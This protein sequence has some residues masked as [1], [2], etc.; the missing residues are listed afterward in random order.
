MLHVVTELLP[1]Q[2]IVRTP[3][4][5]HRHYIYDI[6]YNILYKDTLTTCPTRLLSGPTMFHTSTL[7]SLYWLGAPPHTVSGLF[8]DLIPLFPHSSHYGTVLNNM[9]RNPPMTCIVDVMLFR[10]CVLPVRWLLAVVAYYDLFTISPNMKCS[11]FM[12][13]NNHHFYR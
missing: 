5:L 2:L 13:T 1:K 4:T 12:K 9:V 8:S 10:I 6:S 11:N 3:H 7:R